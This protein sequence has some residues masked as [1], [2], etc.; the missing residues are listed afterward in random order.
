MSGL[1]DRC[2]RDHDRFFALLALGDEQLID[3]IGGR[4]RDALRAEYHDYSTPERSATRPAETICRHNAGYPR[5]LQEQGAARL[6]HV[7]GGTA[8]LC[9]L[10]DAPLVA[11]LGSTRAGDYGT[12]V[13]RGLAR[14]L[15]A[16]GITVVSLLHGGIGG[17][18]QAGAREAGRGGLA[19]V[20][21]GLD[22]SRRGSR[23]AGFVQIS[24]DGCVAS[25]LPASAEGRRWGWLACERTAVQL[26]ALCILVEAEDTPAS[27]AAARMAR[28][29]GRTVAAVPGRVTSRLSDGPNELLR[30][31]ACVVRQ[32][33][34]ALELLHP[35]RAPLQAPEPGTQT[36]EHLEPDLR[37]LLEQVGAGSDTPD[38]LV[39]ASGQALPA[40]LSA[41]S[42]LELRGLLRKG[43]GGRYV[44]RT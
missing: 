16:C 7:A 11:L 44:P 33:Q 22:A 1:L 17:A 18:A 36:V 27:L 43:R 5:A 15:S 42:E 35:L 31:G 26:A 39:R 20:G 10:L 34:D 41:L 19:L 30:E 29:L 4:R 37:H 14:S 13:A 8:R 40:V 32:A 2:A 12:E 23:R 6:L 25:E 21:D 24:R 38:A 28:T 3:A 9:T